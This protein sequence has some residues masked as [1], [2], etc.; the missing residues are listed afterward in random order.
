MIKKVIWILAF[1]LVTLSAF[2]NNEYYDKIGRGKIIGIALVSIVVLA[3]SLVLII[4]DEKKRNP[5]GY[6]S[7]AFR[8]FTSLWFN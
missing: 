7:K 6:F 3:V 2:I 5:Q 8:R 1:I 4:L